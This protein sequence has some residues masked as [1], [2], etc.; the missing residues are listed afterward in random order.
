MEKAEILLEAF[1]YIRRFYGKTIVIKYG[2]SAMICEDLKKSFAMD[3]KYKELRKR[4]DAA[5]VAEERYGNIGPGVE[6]G[7]VQRF[8]RGIAAAHARGRCEIEADRLP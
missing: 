7:R 8:A 5:K 3:A 6:D 2:G 4:A 1:P